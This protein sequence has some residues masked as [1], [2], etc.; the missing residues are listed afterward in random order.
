ME[1]DNVRQPT[2]SPEE[3]ELVEYLDR[4]Y[5]VKKSVAICDS[6]PHELAYVRSR[7]SKLLDLMQLAQFETPNGNLSLEASLEEYQ[8]SGEKTSR[9]AFAAQGFCGDVPYTISLNEV[10]MPDEDI[11]FTL[12][13]ALVDRKGYLDNASASEYELTA[14]DSTITFQQLSVFL[15]GILRQ[16]SIGGT[17]ER[18]EKLIMTA[19]EQP[20]FALIAQMIEQIGGAYGNYVEQVSKETLYPESIDRSVSMELTTIEYSDATQ[21]ILKT[22]AS[23]FPAHALAKVAKVITIEKQSQSVNVQTDSDTLDFSVKMRVNGGDP[24]DIQPGAVFAALDG[25]SFLTTNTVIEES[26]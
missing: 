24:S 15:Y 25:L 5:S 20:N 14:T 18:T 7:H 1:F 8:T 21:R 26:L 13:Y 4:N 9:Y 12:R 17:S 6:I 11:S 19:L 23:H 2:F 16:E 10:A 3:E 22:S